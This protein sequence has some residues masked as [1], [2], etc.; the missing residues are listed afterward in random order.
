LAAVRALRARLITEGTAAHPLV[1]AHG[2]EKVA[3]TIERMTVNWAVV[4]GLT[5]SQRTAIEDWCKSMNT[6]LAA[7]STPNED[8]LRRARENT[9]GAIMN[10]VRGAPEVA[11]RFVDEIRAFAVDESPDV[12][13]EIAR[14]IR[15]LWNADITLQWDLA[16]GFAKMET[17]ARVL[18]QLLNF[19]IRVSND[20]PDRIDALT[21]TIL[22]RG[23]IEKSEGRDIFHE[24]IGT[25]VFHLWTRHGRT[26]ARETID[27]WLADRTTFK[28]E[29]RHGAFSIREGLVVGYDNDNSLDQETRSRCQKLSFEIIDRSARGLEEYIALDRPDQTDARSAEASEDAALLNQMSDKLFFAVGAPDRKSVV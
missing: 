13:D 14:R 28:A 4:S 21:Q 22:Q 5:V 24:G 1:A 9:A 2:W 25:L 11:A 7:L 8:M 17:N 3:W 20:E 29:L 16:E 10:I 26:A 15:Y 18:V 6:A 19:L 23:N 27:S 12:R